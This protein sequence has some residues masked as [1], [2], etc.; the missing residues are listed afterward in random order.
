MS[1]SLECRADRGDPN[2]NRMRIAT[3]VLLFVFQEQSDSIRLDNHGGIVY[4]SVD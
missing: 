3:L 2:I 4:S 1:V